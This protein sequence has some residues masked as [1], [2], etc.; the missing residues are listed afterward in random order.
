MANHPYL[1]L[2]VA[3]SFILP[4]L[5]QI[6]N[7]EFGKGVRFIIAYTIS[8]ALSVIGIGWFLL[9]IVWV[10]SMVDAYQSTRRV[11]FPPR[12]ALPAPGSKA[13]GRRGTL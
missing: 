12:R 4:G 1:G 5:G 11:P 2:A 8:W 3:L 9:V 13:A 10:W 7:Q 6:Y